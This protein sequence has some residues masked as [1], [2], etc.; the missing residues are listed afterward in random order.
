MVV[1]VGDDVTPTQFGEEMWELAD[2]IR[3]IMHQES[4]IMEVQEGG[5]VYGSSF[6]EVLDDARPTSPEYTYRKKHRARPR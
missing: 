4:V 3:H 1:Y 2:D 6:I 5:K